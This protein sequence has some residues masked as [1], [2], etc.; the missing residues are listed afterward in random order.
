M[1]ARP[2]PD[3][4]ISAFFEASQPEL[5]DRAFDA[6]RREIHRTR[7]RIVVGPLRAPDSL[8]AFRAVLAAAA[9]LV[10]AV[11][12]LNLR[13]VLGPVGPFGPSPSPSPTPT[14]VPAPSTGPSPTAS[15]FGPTTFVSPLYGY[16]VIVPAG[17]LAAEAFL[18]WDGTRQPGAD[19]DTDKFVGPGQLIVHAFAG[20]FAG[21]L[22]AFV[23]D[24]IAA[25]TRDHSDT[26]PIAKPE[27]NERL[28]IAGR[29]WVLLG[30]NCGAL[31][32]QAVTVRGGV[33]YAFTLRDLSIQVATEPADRAQ[34]L[35][36][37]D[38]VELPS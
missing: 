37:L 12:F 3:Q 21:D 5:P 38:S 29:D 6:V 24:R 31:I 26:C 17:W 9:V 4:L 15:P 34:L 32:N 28:K 27:I 36:I 13:P 7:Q 22:A 2:D 10:V 30:W 19:V 1:T 14:V 23:T 35:S 8:L 11:A 20:P 16:T 33:A 18:R 25:N